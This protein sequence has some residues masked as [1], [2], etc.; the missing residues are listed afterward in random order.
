[1]EYSK[2][3]TI[4]SISGLFGAM[5]YQKWLMKYEVRTIVRWSIALG[6]LS[7]FTDYLFVTRV[8]KEAFGIEDIYYLYATSLIFGT[9]SNAISFLPIM[10]LFAR[11]IPK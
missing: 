8:T 6:V 1:M 5:I 9:V 2:I 10:A 4:S 3:A 7:G 11:I